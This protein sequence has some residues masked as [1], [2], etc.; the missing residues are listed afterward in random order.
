MVAVAIQ[1]LLKK[2]SVIIFKNPLP[3]DVTMQLDTVKK[4]EIALIIETWLKDSKV[5]IFT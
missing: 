4:N 5:G 2:V 3:S 1:M